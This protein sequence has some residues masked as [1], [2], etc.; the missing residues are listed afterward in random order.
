MHIYY[1]NNHNSEHSKNLM[2][3]CLRILNNVR[4]GKYC[5]NTGNS[6]A[7][8][9]IDRKNTVYMNSVKTLKKARI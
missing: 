9:Y 7:Y 6:S 3:K 5:K 1:L 2:V 8:L 4:L